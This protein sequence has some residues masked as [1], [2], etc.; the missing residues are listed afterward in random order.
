MRPNLKKIQLLLEGSTLTN[1]QQHEL[2][3]FL[4]LADDQDLQ[5]VVGLFCERNELIAILYQNIKEK[6]RALKN[7]D[8]SAWQ[9]IF[10]N[11]LK[12]LSPTTSQ[13]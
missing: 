12:I 6:R 2:V 10:K 7:K 1:Q 5:G 9:Q 8:S 3:G 11:E 13:E 4:A